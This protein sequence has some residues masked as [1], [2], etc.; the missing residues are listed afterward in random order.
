MKTC[1]T[2]LLVLTIMIARAQGP[3][4]KIGLKL[5]PEMTLKFGNGYDT[6]PSANEA[7][8]YQFNRI[9]TGVGAQVVLPLYSFIKLETGIYLHK[10]S[11]EYDRFL[12]FTY[13][14]YGKYH[15]ITTF[16]FIQIPLSLRFDLKYLYASFG[17][18]LNYQSTTTHK[19]DGDPIKGD[20]DD[21]KWGAGIISTLG[22]D[23]PVNKNISIISE[24]RCSGIPGMGAGMNVG[25]GVGANYKF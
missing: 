19:T 4:L 12:R 6:N 1:Y 21:G 17:S 15:I 22:R 14:T 25:V 2:F 5:V 9:T 11:Y 8:D 18:S 24:L 10:Q 20:G 3:D 16:N 13:T 23:W 7:R